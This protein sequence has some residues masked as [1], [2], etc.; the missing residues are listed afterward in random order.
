MGERQIEVLVKVG[1]PDDC[2]S[3]DDELGILLEGVA[4]R[5][6]HR[7]RSME[8]VGEY[9]PL[10]GYSVR[11]E[12]RGIK[13]EH[14]RKGYTGD[15]EVDVRGSKGAT[16]GDATEGVGAGGE[17]QGRGYATQAEEGGATEEGD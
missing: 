10:P 17:C 9:G 14:R 2:V 16:D 15:G 8:R 1:V 12:I 3:A 4:Y 11:W 5:L 13:D 7:W 6:R